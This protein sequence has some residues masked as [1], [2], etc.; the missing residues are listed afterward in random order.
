[1]ADDPAPMPSLKARIA[2]LNLSETAGRPPP[3]YGQPAPVKKRPPPPPPANPPPRLSADDRSQSVNLPT[4]SYAP[5]DARSIGNLPAESTPQQKR[6]L[7]PPSLGAATEARPSLP[8]RPTR[9]LQNAPTLPPRR[10]SEQSVR[11]KESQESISTV[12]SWRSAGSALSGR[13][14]VTSGTLYSEP[15]ASSNRVKAPPFDPSKL[16][17]LPPKRTQE[18]K[19]A[20]LA[21]YDPVRANRRTSSSHSTAKAPPPALP[22][23]PSLPPR[24]STTQNDAALARKPRRSA[25]EWGM[26]KSTEEAPPLPSGRPGQQ[27]GASPPPPVPLGSRP[28]LATLQASKPRSGATNSCL[29]CRDFRGVDAHAARFPREAIPSH[30]ISW[31]AHQLTDPF[32]SLTDKARALFTWLHHNI[33]YNA[34]AFFNHNVQPSTPASTIATGLAVCEGYAGLF[35]AL[36]TAVG[37]ESVV[38][39][40]HGKGFGHSP[41]TAGA[42]IP[43]FSCGHAWNAVRIDG[44]EWKLIDCCWGAGHIDGGTQAYTRKFSPECFTAD[45]VEFGASHFPENPAYFFRNDPGRPSITWQEYIAAPPGANVYGFAQTAGL[46]KTAFLPDVRQICIYDP[47]PAAAPVIR[48]QWEKRCPHFDGE[49]LGEGKP[50]MFFLA[51]QGRDGRNKQFLPMNT[52]GRFWWLDVERVELGAPGQTIMACAGDKWHGG[53]EGSGRGVTREVWESDRYGFRNYQGIAVWDLA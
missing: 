22:S 2:A 28:D 44:G 41:L 43:P 32:P 15:A 21:R 38:V 19:D 16:P 52:D 1:M 39:G 30:D 17:P 6:V 40:G 18:E 9:S 42:A 12:A 7:P 50:Y 53:P 34:A 29:K 31:L 49:A 26:N 24:P 37:L 33:D 45:N 27:S 4:Q 3:V 35:A 48:F 51:I 46:S 20:E 23:R 10:P 8:P 13:T 5:T 47:D 36:A 25:L 14:S 11:R